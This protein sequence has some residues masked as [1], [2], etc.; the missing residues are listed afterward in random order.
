MAV[1]YDQGAKRFI[2]RNSWG[3]RWGKKGYFTITFEYLEML[4]ADFWTIRK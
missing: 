3:E 1:G 4:A 2:A